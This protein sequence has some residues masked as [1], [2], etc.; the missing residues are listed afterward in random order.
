MQPECLL[1]LNPPMR[2]VQEEIFGPLPTVMPYDSLDEV[3]DYI[4]AGER[5]L[6]LYLFSNDRTVQE[7]VLYQT[8]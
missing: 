2:I 5:P 6:A 4:N 1:A 3:L 8:L 7:R